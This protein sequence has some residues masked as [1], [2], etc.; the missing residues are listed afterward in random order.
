MYTPTPEHLAELQKAAPQAKFVIA[1]NEDQAAKLLENAQVVLGNRYFLQSLPR[2]KNLR[3]MQ[4]NS[5]GVDLILSAGA[6]LEGITIT[7][8]R[9]V[10]D[11]E[12]AD[13]ALALILA[14]LRELHHLRDDQHR[15][16]WQRHSLE[17]IQG[18]MV[19]L[20]GWGGVGRGLAK[21]LAALGASVQ[22]VRRCIDKPGADETGFW[23]WTPSSW[24]NVLPR[25]D[26]LVLAL[27]LTKETFHLI[28]NKELKMLPRHAYVV[29]VGRGG[30]MDDQALLCAVQSGQIK[31]AALDVFE[32]EPLPSEHAFWREK[33]ILL[34]PHAARSL[35]KPP[36]RWESLFVENVR[37]YARGEMLVN[38]VD[39]EAG[40]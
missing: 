9:G 27:P 6:A 11:D 25:V 31:G 40:Y 36:C 8:A 7:C 14:L 3:W 22:G 35:E 33:N 28:G 29:N 20:L 26:I 19:L 39:K 2:A 34:S 1:H 24:R 16:V 15:G 32:E 10:Y 17:T 5:V 21:R 37:R 30:T 18:K 13:H 12:M 23:V 38:I 4:S